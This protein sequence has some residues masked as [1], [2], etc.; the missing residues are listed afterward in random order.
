V[1]SQENACKSEKN[2]KN[3]HK[4]KNVA[5]IQVSAEKMHAKARR[6]GKNTVRLHQNAWKRTKK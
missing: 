4:G 6:R 3:T 5:K 2:S 1:S